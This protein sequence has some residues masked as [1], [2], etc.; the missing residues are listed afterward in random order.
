MIHI[1][2]IGASAL[3][4]FYKNKKMIPNI[5]SLQIIHFGL[6]NHVLFGLVIKI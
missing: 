3:K 2:F 4:R 1:K 5:T 6:L